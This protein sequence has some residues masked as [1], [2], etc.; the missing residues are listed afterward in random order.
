[1]SVKKKLFWKDLIAGKDPFTVRGSLVTRPEPSIVV[2]AKGALKN[3]GELISYSFCMQDVTDGDP[4]D[5]QWTRSGTPCLMDALTVTSKGVTVEPNYVLTE[6]NKVLTVP[7]NKLQLPRQGARTLKL[8]VLVNGA[9]ASAH[10]FYQ[11]TQEDRGFVEVAE[12]KQALYAAVFCLIAGFRCEFPEYGQAAVVAAADWLLGESVG[13]ELSERTEVFERFKS[14][15]ESTPPVVNWSRACSQY[16]VSIREY[17]NTEFRNGII[18]LFYSV[19]M[20]EEIGESC[21]KE[22]P[23]FYALCVAIGVDMS[24]FSRLSDKLLLACDLSKHEPDSLL[25][26][27]DRMDVDEMKKHLRGEYKRWN[28]R[29]THSDDAV[30]EKAVFMLELI[31]NRRKQ[32]TA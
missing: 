14:L 9:S 5:F 1:M 2:E 24:S 18:R 25:G 13:W 26:L 6:W 29:A 10:A 7:L 27:H 3:K 22:L 20:G 21:D 23:V 31:S 17:A 16:A 4:C 28:D 8:S 12:S 30:R 32:L 19:L 15:A 11:H